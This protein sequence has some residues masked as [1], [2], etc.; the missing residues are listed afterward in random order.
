MRDGIPN[1]RNVMLLSVHRADRR[2]S[3]S[4]GSP[5]FARFAFASAFSAALWL[6][7]FAA[8]LDL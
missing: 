2:P 7:I 5:V 1:Q 8:P 6:A 4:E 3:A